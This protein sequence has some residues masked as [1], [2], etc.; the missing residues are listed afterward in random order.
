MTKQKNFSKTE[1]NETKFDVQRKPCKEN[2]DLAVE[3]TIP[4]SL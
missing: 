3:K 2:V 4:E 1:L